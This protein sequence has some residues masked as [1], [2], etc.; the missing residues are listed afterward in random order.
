MNGGSTDR[1]RA[2][3]LVIQPYIPEYRVPLFREMK[4]RLALDAIDLRV[5]SATASRADGARGDDRARDTADFILDQRRISVAGRTLLL[6]RIGPVLASFDPQFVIVE[7]ALKNLELYELLARRVGGRGPRLAMWGQ[8]R[9]YST[10]QSGA[11]AWAKQRAT[12]L[13]DWFFAYTQGGAD[14]VAGRG[15]PAGRITVLNNSIDTRALQQ[16]MAAVS[17]EELSKFRATHGLTVGRT[18]LFLGG[19]DGRK[20]IAFLLEAAEE[21]ARRL[22][23]FVL[24]V[25]GSGE[26]AAKVASVQQRGGPVRHLGRLD[27][28]SK[29]LALAASDVLVIPEWVGLVAVDSLAAGRPVMTTDHPSHSPEFEYLVPGETVVVSRHDAA[30]FAASVADTLSSPDLLERMRGACLTAAEHLSIEAMAGRFA[31][32]IVAWTS[33][34]NPGSRP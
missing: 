30:A 34:A 16:Q 8:G 20:G 33:R 4:S 29:A 19:L 18:G 7:Q 32:G 24:L 15:F 23:G 2:R 10:A 17:E 11:E 31:A 28:P 26:D 25:G 5:A 6:R 12:R 13:T 1:N 21:I 27:G 9:S 22:P 3:V 14:Y